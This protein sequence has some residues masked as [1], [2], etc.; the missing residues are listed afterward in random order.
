MVPKRLLV[1]IALIVVGLVGVLSILSGYILM[2]RFDSL[3]QVQAV[4][5][6]SRAVGGLHA[7]LDG[8]S[9]GV[10][11]WAAWDDS[12]VFLR[13]RNQ[14]FIR[15]NMVPQS[16]ESLS[17]DI[18]LFLGRE[19]Q[20]FEGWSWN[21]YA[22]K[23]EP[24]PS[25]LI[26]YISRYTRQFVFEW[27]Q[28][29]RQGI[30]LLQRAPLLLA[31]QAVGPSDNS[32]PSQGTI[33]MGRYLDG[34]VAARMASLTH[35]SLVFN[36]MPD[37]RTS[38]GGMAF[39]A[40]GGETIHLFPLDDENMTGT[41]DF[42]D[43]SG[44]GILQMEVRLHREIHLSGMNAVNYLRFWLIVVCVSASAV[45]MFLVSRTATMRAHREEA[46]RDLAAL[47][48][49]S[50]DAIIGSMADGRIR[51]W[52]AGAE[53]LYGYSAAE[54]VGRNL[55]D[56]V[57]MSDV[58]HHS[59]EI[60]R[61]TGGHRP[62]RF[63][64]S[65][66]TRE[67]RD[68]E[69]AVTVSPILSADGRVCG[70]STIARDITERKL[71]ERDLAEKKRLLDEVFFNI[72]EGIGLVDAGMHVLF[73]NPAF[74]R[75]LDLTGEV[76]E[77][78]SL[79]E[80]VQGCDLSVLQ[81]QGP[82]RPGHENAEIALELRTSEG[83]RRAV[84]LKVSPWRTSGN[85]RAG[86]F[87]VLSD[88][89]A[90]TMAEEALVRA[91]EELELR[92]RERTAELAMANEYLVAEAHER[93]KASQELL[94]AKEAAEAANQAKSQFLANISHEI[95]TPLNA[96]TGYAE[97]L[98]SAPPRD[99]VP[100]YAGLILS[101]S[102]LLLELIN[103]V[104]DM[105]KIEAGKMELEIIPFDLSTV[106]RN[107]KS[108]LMVRA[109]SK[110]LELHV[111]TSPDVVRRLEGD[112]TRLR[113]ILLNL[114][115]NAVKFTERGEV[116]IRGELL[117]QHQDQVWLRFSV[118]DTGI[119]IPADK[120]D[121][122]FDSFVQADGSTT[123][124]FGGT[125]LGTTIARRLVEMMDGEIGVW[126]TLGA[127]STFWFTARF[128]LRRGDVEPS[129]EMDLLREENVAGQSVEESLPV[130]GICGNVLLVED[131]PPNRE[132]ARAHLEA[133]G[134]GVSCASNG[135]EALKRIMDEQFEL[136]VMDVQMPV[137]DGLEATRRIRS[138]EGGVPE[139]AIL[140]MTANAFPQDIAMCHEAGMD[141]VLTKPVRRHVLQD[142]VTRLAGQ[143]SQRRWREC[144]SPDESSSCQPPEKGDSTPLDYPKALVEF[145]GQKGLLDSLVVEFL[146]VC[147]AQVPVL[148]E[149]QKA[150]ELETVRRE[151]H[152]IKG[153]AGNIVAVPLAEIAASL[154]LTAREGDGEACLR[155]LAALEEAVEELARFMQVLLGRRI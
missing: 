113:Q 44:A 54:A 93:L 127:G 131:Y 73:A 45:I 90:S 110:K 132:I 115:G 99:K 98:C 74:F 32:G 125:G 112:P 49:S 106:L 35:L 144:I 75:I 13:D 67:G 147:R 50:E 85:E 28:Q 84:L 38:K 86:S 141:E 23:R 143:T 34:M 37:G 36:A 47:V 68:I 72:Q 92:V 22:E 17:V 82:R 123:R 24:V 2:K 69:V 71:V 11:D 129:G 63:E 107:V 46:L 61:E 65:T 80:L 77:G 10:N 16:F 57:P 31:F 146:S 8:M 9:R 70:T 87:L 55:E 40:E 52:N 41:M 111:E 59:G 66:K 76:L 5:D 29:K 117:R 30:L 39:P 155:H 96:V 140:G 7:E 81:R 25:E 48:E 137:M 135:A 126:S 26:T 133:L 154:E 153:G 142:A 1:I 97:L 18:I 122:I 150:G 15:S 116:R 152:K 83:E 130:S 139:I 145:A 19:G 78:K 42:R 33:I 20:F 4:R 21:R 124:R 118:T 64:A 138:G 51:S 149:A 105:S 60:P 79:Q 108:T 12:C 3:E 120:L 14:A 148:K 95:R 109:R 104:L 27:P 56:L 53:V 121:T 102:D 94:R 58:E 89:T 114:G 151:A 62:A 88:V 91:R 119:G 100:V 134:F 128:L 6:V 43:L 136:V 101:E 103:D